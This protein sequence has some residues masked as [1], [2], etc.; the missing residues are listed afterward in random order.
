[1]L[2]AATQDWAHRQTRA[3]TRSTRFMCQQCCKTA[4][5]AV[6]LS[7]NAR[8]ESY[9]ALAADA[10]GIWL[11]LALTQT[12]RRMAKEELGA[13]TITLNTI[14]PEEL[15][16]DNPTRIKTGRLVPKVGIPRHATSDIQ[17]S[18]P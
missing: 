14:A 10:E 7:R 5:L 4:G 16:E 17:Y 3:S 2:G 9:W 8:G 15:A 11:P 18:F 12:N 1:M 13:K 6:R